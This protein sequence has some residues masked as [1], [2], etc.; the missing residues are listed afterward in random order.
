MP[1][2]EHMADVLRSWGYSATAVIL[3][4]ECYGVPQTRK[5]A[6]LLARLDGPVR[7]PEADAPEVPARRGAG[8]RVWA[9]LFGDGLLPWVSM[10]EALGWVGGAVGVPAASR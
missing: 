6:F 1:I 2:W 4:S 3:H 9:D 8:R 5:R 10:A 7:G